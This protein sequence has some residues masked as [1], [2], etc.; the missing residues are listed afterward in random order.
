M[1]VEREA[2]RILSAS[3]R[4]RGIRRGAA[5][6]DS[7]GWSRRRNP[8]VRRQ[9]HASPGGAN[10]VP[11]FHHRPNKHQGLIGASIARSLGSYSYLVEL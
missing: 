3:L 1:S 7:P 4:R 8:G 6:D 10:Q 9:P 2:A 11:E 5:T